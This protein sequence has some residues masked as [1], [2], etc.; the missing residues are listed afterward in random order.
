[1]AAHT[2]RKH[3]Q[4]RQAKCPLIGCSKRMRKNGLINH[5]VDKHPAEMKRLADEKAE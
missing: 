1:M 2:E 5:I 4:N 3:Q